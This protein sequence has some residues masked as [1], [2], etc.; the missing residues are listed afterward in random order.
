MAWAEKRGPW[1]RV[2][3]RDANGEV[4]T[5]PDKYRTKKQALAAAEALDTDQ[6]RGMFIDPS[7]GRINLAE[8]AAQ[9]RKAHRVAP[10]TTAKYDHY[11]DHHILPAFGEVTLDGIA[12][13][14]VKQ[15]A[16][17]LGD[18][19]A[20]ATVSGIIT[21]LSVLLTAAVEERML[22]INPIQG[23]RLNASPHVHRGV[24]RRTRPVP[25]GRHVVAI[26]ER[27]R[28][29]H[30]DGPATMVLTAAYTG[31]RWGELA[32]LAPVNC[33]LEDGYLRIDPD[34]GALHEVGTQVWLG[35]PKSS[36]AA[37][38]IDLPPFL[39]DML[40]VVIEGGS[41]DR[42]FT[43]ADGGVLRRS[44]FCRRIWR[45]PAC[46]GYPTA[47]EPVPPIL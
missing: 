6:R 37:R 10:S 44:N 39:V 22:A 27:I 36:A 23:L 7:A 16:G 20:P 46:D 40:S 14:A 31:M 30:G 1:Y 21:L 11:L 38:R 13:L 33:H 35:P 43:A 17:Q 8:W 4:N 12:R 19:Y 5:T 28:S 41:G 26:A 9:W 42:V 29:D 2:R 15:W 47:E 25:D 24:K 45:R 32:G 34:V 18:R 3:W